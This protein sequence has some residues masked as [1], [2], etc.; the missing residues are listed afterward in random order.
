MAM[1]T[2][3]FAS[4]ALA[5]IV[6]PMSLVN[7]Q[8]IGES[9][10]NIRITE[11]KYGVVLTASLKG[12][13]PGLHGFH[14]HQNASCEAKEK[15]GKKEPAGAAGG[16]FDPA[17]TA[18]HGTPWGRGHLGDLPPLYVNA[19]GSAAQPVLAPRLTLKE[20]TGHSLIIHA[21]G[22]NHADQPEKLGGGGAR[23]AC[24]VIQ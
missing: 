12:L 14:L 10:G 9:A 17:N 21:G 15:D 20:L 16:H 22:D 6:V 23:V 24:G 18:Q 7:E 19:D 13:T 8:G 3:L 2:L 4:S 5:D 1:L 11:S